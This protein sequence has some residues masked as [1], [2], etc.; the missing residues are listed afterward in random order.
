MMRAIRAVST[1]RGRDPRGFTLFAYGGAGPIHA[2]ALAREMEIK[3]IVI[4]PS[5]GLFSAF[6]LLSA[7]IEH[8]VTETFIHRLDESMIDRVNDVW[9]RME[10]RAL[11]EIEASGY[12]DVKVNIRKSIEARY[13]GQSSELPI[14]IPWD[15]MKEEHIPTLIN[16]FHQEHLKI[17]AHNRPDEP[18]DLITLRLIASVQYEEES[19]P[20]NFRLVYPHSEIRTAKQA[21]KA[22]FG[23]EFGWLDTT[24]ISKDDMSDKVVKGPA[25]IELYDSTCVIPPYAHAYLGPLEAIIIEINS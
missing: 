1:M 21:R 2:A 13:T 22:Y 14:A 5:P 3:K 4:P 10:E 11:N 8:H 9:A 19:I 6:G 15:T 7:Q 12:G 23:Q 17:Y 18:I 20:T 16:A 24:V 25:I